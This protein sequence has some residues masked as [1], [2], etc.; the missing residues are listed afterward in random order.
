NTL[1]HETDGSFNPGCRRVIYQR[2]ANSLAKLQLRDVFRLHAKFDL[3]I[4][5][6]DELNKRTAC[7]GNLT[8][9]DIDLG[10]NARDVRAD[11]IVGGDTLGF[12]ALKLQFG[13][14]SR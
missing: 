12:E 9:F 10:N 14:G 5:R 3:Y 8:I 2:Y 1:R 7:T 11:F 13:V 6:G 4:A